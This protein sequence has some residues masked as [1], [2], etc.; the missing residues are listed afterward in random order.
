MRVNRGATAI[1]N[2]CIVIVGGLFGFLIMPLAG[3]L[4]GAPL[5]TPVYLTLGFG[6]IVVS[7][8]ALAT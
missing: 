1:I 6:A 4:A 5:D 8:I 7:G 2:G 3:Q